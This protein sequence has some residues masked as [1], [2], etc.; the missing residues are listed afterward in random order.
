MKKQP[1]YPIKVLNKFFLIIEILFQQG[2]AVNMT[3]I[4]FILIWSSWI[5]L[6]FCF[7]A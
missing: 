4:S 5:M 2:S 3:G 6:W 1:N 7:F